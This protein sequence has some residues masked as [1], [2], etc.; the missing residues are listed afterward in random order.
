M[1]QATNIN[2]D[3]IRNILKNSNLSLDAKGLMA[4]IIHI[5]SDAKCKIEDIYTCS[6]VSKKQI[7]EFLH[8]LIDNKY[9]EINNDGS[10]IIKR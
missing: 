8:E 1:C 4:T 3:L 6:K 5:S 7:D 2:D 10:I 9:V